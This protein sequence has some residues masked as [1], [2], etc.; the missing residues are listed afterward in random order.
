MRQDY[1]RLVSDL[2]HEA[3]P[4]PVTPIFRPDLAQEPRTRRKQIVAAGDSSEF[5]R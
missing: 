2:R 1:R 3:T 5:S 4:L